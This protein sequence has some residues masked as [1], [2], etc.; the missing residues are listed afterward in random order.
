MGNIKNDYTEKAKRLKPEF[1]KLNY[2][3]KLK[4]MAENFGEW[5]PSGIKDE[6]GE[7]IIS[8]YPNKTVPDETDPEKKVPNENYKEEIQLYNERLINLNETNKD[9][10][11][12]DLSFDR[13]KL[14]FESDIL[15]IRNSNQHPKNLIKEYI[16]GQLE[17]YRQKMSDSQ[18]KRTKDYYKG[19]WDLSKKVI[20]NSFLKARAGENYI[21]FLQSKIDRAG[22]EPKGFDNLFEDSKIALQIKDILEK[23]GFTKEGIWNFDNIK[24]TKNNTSLVAVYNVLKPLLRTKFQNKVTPIVREFYKE[25]GIEGL[26]DEKSMRNYPSKTDLDIFQ[27]IFQELI[28]NLPLK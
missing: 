16:K 17:T 22:Y 23:N 19:N 11:F 12:I 3:N 25:F 7:I 27:K 13:L 21:A 18:I 6:S 20:D 4:L 1:D 10:L 14:R 28:K 8:V 24:G 9:D 5:F 2:E 15:K 26:I